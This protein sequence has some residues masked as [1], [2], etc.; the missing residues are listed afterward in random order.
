MEKQN[1]S[2][3]NVNV[4]LLEQERQRLHRTLDIQYDKFIREVLTDGHPELIP[5]GEC[6][7]SLEDS[8]GCFKGKKVT[9]I[10]L[11]NGQILPV[12]S[13]KETAVELLRECNTDPVMHERLLALRNIL[14]GRFRCLLSSDADIMST[15][16]QIDEGLYLE[17]KLDT[18]FLLKTVTKEIMDRIGYD[19]SRIGILIKDPEMEIGREQAQHQGMRGPAL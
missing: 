3:R 13:W 19:Y 14:G 1:D 15:P 2:L 5:E 12:R 10:W 9:G 18:E 8:P 17:G 6:L 11:K 7:W 16:L 4:R